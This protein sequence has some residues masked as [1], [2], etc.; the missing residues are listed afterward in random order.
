MLQKCQCL[1]NKMCDSR[2]PS[3]WKLQDGLLERRGEAA[4][5]QAAVSAR[6]LPKGTTAY[7]NEMERLP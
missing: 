2:F 7:G 4:I 3:A 1:V 6:P 5:V